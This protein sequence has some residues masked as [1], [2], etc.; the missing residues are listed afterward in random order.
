MQSGDTFLTKPASGT[1]FF[2]FSVP[3]DSLVLQVNDSRL[4]VLAARLFDPADLL[5]PPGRETPPARFLKPDPIRIAI[6]VVS[7]PEG[8]PLALERSLRWTRAG[9]S[10]S[11]SMGGL[12]EATFTPGPSTVT[13]RVSEGVLAAAP[14]LAAR[15]LLEAPV[16]YLLAQRRYRVVHAAAVV[17]DGRAVVIR[18]AAGAGK[19]TLAGAC[20]AASFDLLADESLLVSRADPDALLAAVRDLAFS[21]ESARL[22]GLLS[23]TEPAFTGGEEKL[24]V[25]LFAASTP[26]RR[27]ARRVA[28]V[29]LGRR[30]GP[31]NLTPIPSADVSA[32][33]EEGAI[34]QEDGLSRAVAAWAAS[35]YR[36][37]G[38]Q[39]LA[40]TVTCVS[41][42]LGRTA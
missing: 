15:Y 41:R 27:R 9:H 33:F 22:T 19:S 34:P 16:T 14:A 13:G 8:D 26:A 4:G 31:L 40:A 11:L 18:G 35:T 28:T 24:R 3:E 1:D 23:R 42:L 5:S 32:A 21:P 30:D 37:T 12:L 20:L 6:E 10:W 38:H 25:D 7:G 17:F 36:L 29:L 39:D 2:S